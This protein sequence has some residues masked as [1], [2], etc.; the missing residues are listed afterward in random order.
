MIG[1]K[2]PKKKEKAASKSKA[3]NVV[4]L[5]DYIANPSQTPGH[6]HEKLLYRGSRNFISDEFIS[7]QREMV[8]LAS[9]AVRSTMP[10]S[11]YLLS[12]KEGEH[13]TPE[14]IEE[15]VDIVLEELG[16]IGCQTMFGVHDDTN[17]QHAH[18]AIN[19]VDPVTDK[20]RKANRGF[21]IEAMHRAVARI[22]KL[23]G[24]ER[25]P[26]ARY[27]VLENGQVVQSFKVEGSKPVKQ[28]IVDKENV[29]GEKSATRI[30]IEEAG[31]I[32][33]TATSWREVHDG[34][35]KIGMRY[36][37]FG[38]GA[39]VFVGEVG[40]KASDVDKKASMSRMEKR[41]GIFE[42]ANQ[43]SPNVFIVHTPEPHPSYA[44]DPF[45]GPNRLRKLSERNVADHH[46]ENRATGVLQIDARTLGHR[47]NAVRRESDAGRAKPGRRSTGREPEPITPGIDGWQEYITARCVHYHGK[48]NETLALRRR[49]D[50]ERKTFAQEQA[51]YRASALRGSWAG[52]GELR[53][54][55]ESAV[56]Y[57]R[58]TKFAELQERQK[59]ERAEVRAKYRPFPSL[60]LWQRQ[61]GRDDLAEQ[62]RERA[63]TPA[64]IIGDTAVP[65]LPKDIRAYQHHVVGNTV[66]YR[67]ADD[68]GQAL[69]PAFVDRGNR[70]D[71]HAWRDEGA[72]LA[73]LQ[74]SAAK[75]TKF[76]VSGSDEYKAMCV[77]LAALHGLKITNPELQDRIT[78]ERTRLRD[79]RAA[80]MK[81]NE[82]VQFEKYH[83]AV[84]AKRYRVTAIKMPE[85]GG[86]PKV[87]I[88]DKKGGVTVG[89]TPDEI[90]QRTPELR[91]LQARGEN[92][93]YTPL[94]ADKHHILL[95]D[96]NRAKLDRLIADG[97]K[98][99]AVIESSP[100][101][102]QALI[103]IP[104][105]GT[106]HD[107]DVSNRLTVALNTEY[108]DPHLSGA[109]HPHRAPG[110]ENRKPKHLREDGSYPEVK[111]PRA[112]RREC[113]KTLA[114]SREI[115]AEYETLSVKRDWP[116]EAP[117]PAVAPRASAIDSDRG[118]DITVLAYKRHT[119]DVI[120]RQMGGRIDR[121]RV[122]SMVAVRLAVT[123][124]S[125]VDIER[126]V[127][128]CAPEIRDD[129]SH[130]WGDYARRTAAYAFSPKG[131]NQVEAY[132]KYQDQWT[133][134]EDEVRKQHQPVAHEKPDDREAAEKTR[135]IYKYK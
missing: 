13:P 58:A 69:A 38:S 59:S 52:R 78:K 86:E 3:A 128:Q 122:D 76:Q 106:P 10:V 98:P 120:A 9:E 46:P 17:N 4:A 12:W 31:P 131:Q 45:A 47:A 71:V 100:G 28:H 121:S 39:K 79:E 104:K 41:L 113:D 27:Q 135:D 118:A 1:K 33:M 7:Q 37:R 42:P 115:N 83:A 62:W 109:I 48:E 114:L 57:E 30:A 49:H 101:N 95:D 110:Y 35:E 2:I 66:Q 72:T 123:G 21:D 22:E 20:V 50:V 108:G 103:T 51:K 125:Q 36:E 91:R 16:L 127:F 130:N 75:W 74:L 5:T 105:L 93:Y 55:I 29:T 82:L 40:V 90:A 25:E 14:Q 107:R 24:W 32:L 124:H 97:Y 23:Q 15:A 80:A 43:E 94:S 134:M 19:R 85:N 44:R 70:I 68:R 87:F 63:S 117:A 132:R 64:Q 65:A 53:N 6:E 18:I 73:A 81:A 11:H 129:S 102:F 119:A 60:E 116:V 34:L 89:F 126:A 111:L 8:S 92:I 26:N 56:A 84:G 61:R 54:A 67:I 96:V 88:V 77:W 99:A 133:R 112:E